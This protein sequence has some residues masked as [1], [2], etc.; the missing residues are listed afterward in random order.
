VTA[1]VLVDAGPL[2][3]IFSHA[4]AH[5]ST[6]VGQLAEIFG[7][8]LTCWPVI[9]EA[10]Y[11]LRR[12][13]GNVQNLLTSIQDGSLRLLALEAD[14]IPW[15]AR[16][17]STYRSLGADLADAALVFLAEREAI[18]T[19]F[20]LDHRDFSVYRV[21]RSRKLRILPAIH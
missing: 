2:V 21:H 16:F 5:H 8:L 4:D 14:A 11:L 19:V 9:T 12:H 1:R 7:P 13:P 6:C 20:T 15:I 17:L 3:A 18:D 10:A